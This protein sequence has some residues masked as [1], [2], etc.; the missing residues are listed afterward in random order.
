[1]SLF[2]RLSIVIPVYNEERY[3]DCVVERVLKVEVGGLQ[4][5]IIIVNDYSTDRTAEI[6]ASLS[7][8]YKE[9][10]V[11]HQAVNMGKGAALR[12]GF[13]EATGDI[14]LIQ[15]AELE[16]DPVD[17]PDLL[18]PILD[19]RADVVYGSRFLGGPH[20]V[21]FFCHQVANL[22]LTLLSNITTNL[23]LSDME[24]GYKVLRQMCYAV[25]P[26]AQIDMVLSPR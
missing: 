21:L 23:N 25:L 20:R 8:Q 10:H 9:I 26:C 3:L 11:Y 18:A 17:Y 19:G 14:I 24:T 2:K 7:D 6:L 13:D 1:M 16:Y 12:R 5:E 15:D 4:K 22:F